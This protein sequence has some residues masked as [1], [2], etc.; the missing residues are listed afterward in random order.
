MCLQSHKIGCA[1]NTCFADLVI[2]KASYQLLPA[3][4]DLG[5]SERGG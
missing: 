1:D 4:A 2:F 3:G 5:F